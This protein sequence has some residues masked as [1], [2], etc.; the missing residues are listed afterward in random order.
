LA[1]DPEKCQALGDAA[2]KYV[3]S[4]FD[5]SVVGSLYEDLYTELIA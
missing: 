4:H 5:F 1:N 3:A 2:Q